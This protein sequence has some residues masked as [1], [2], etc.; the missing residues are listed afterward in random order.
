MST[1]QLILS[2]TDHYK[3]V[4]DAKKPQYI[5]HLSLDV[6]KAFDSVHHNLLLYKLRT[7][8][9]FSEPAV[10]LFRSYLSCRSQCMKVGSAISQ[11]LPICKGV[12]QGSVLGPLLFNL[13]VNDLL[14]ST[15]NVFS[16]ADDT[17]LFVVGDTPQAALAAASD[18][19]HDLSSW[20]GDNALGLCPQKTTCILYSNRSVPSNM[21]IIL[22]NH[23]TQV[24]PTVRMLGITLDSKL[25]FV[26]HTRRLVSEVGNAL[27]ALRKVR[28]YLTV[29]DC[30][31]VYTSMIRSKLE[32]CSNV[33][34]CSNRV[35]IRTDI[36]NCQ[37]R[38]IRVICGVRKN[39]A[40]AT[41]S[42]TVARNELGLPTLSNRRADRFKRFVRL[43]AG[44]K[45]SPYL[46]NLLDSC[47][48]H[49]RSM[50]NKCPYV[51]PSVRSNFGKS[52]FVYQAVTALKA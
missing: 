20:Y 29:A 13:M 23:P 7:M 14:I 22:D 34:F 41:F 48:R 50:R 24:E 26:E 42:V 2:V 17:L 18:K 51:T 52:R 40:S 44:G 49:T 46:Y 31:R 43:L 5:A 6:K 27:Y 12:P 33:L 21:R 32:Y 35:D 8:F 37:S 30:L 10:S 39:T 9:F 47:E 36:E 11:S 45:G 1:E 25:T 15:T 38:A 19:F 28:A 16:Y 4:L 3:Q